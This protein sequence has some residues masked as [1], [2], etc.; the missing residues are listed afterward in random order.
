LEFGAADETQALLGNICEAIEQRQREAPWACGLTLLGLSKRLRLPE[1][2]LTSSLAAFVEGGLLVRRAGYYMMP[3]FIPELTE[4]QRA[5]FEAVIPLDRQPPHLPVA[6][7]RIATEMKFA[8]IAGLHHAFEALLATGVLVQIGRDLYRAG[9]IE[10][11]RG[12]LE[13][14]LRD[15][16]GITPA[17]F[18]DLIG[19]SR[20][21]ALPLLEWFDAANITIRDGDVR[22]LRDANAVAQEA[23]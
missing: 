18:R 16:K 21:Y 2:E 23:R 8:R 22:K 14:A 9:Q 13:A 10:A 5:F 4:P 7:D 11:I 19:T 6:F 20:K 17:Q 3:D 15:G 1:E 12:C